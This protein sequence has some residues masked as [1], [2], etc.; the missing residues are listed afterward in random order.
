MKSYQ[1][2]TKTIMDTT[3]PN[4]VFNEYGESDYYTNFI[5]NILPEWNYGRDR[6]S[7]LM[8]FAD[9]V[10]KDGKNKKFDCIIGVSGGLDSSF[11]V[12]ITTE[13][14][15]LRPLIYHVDAGWN[16]EIA[17]SNIE[18]LINT[19]NLDLYTDVINWEEMKS[20]QRAFFHS[21]IP[22]QDC[23]QDIAF[24]SSLYEFARKNNIKYVFTGA[25]YS[26]EC[27]R[28]PNEWGAYPGID[29]TLINDIF[30][31]HG[32]GNLKTFPIIDIFKY[33]IFYQKIIGMKVFHPLNYVIY[34]K[35]DAE[36]LLN[37]KFG[38][39]SFQHKHH[40]S[41]FTRFIEDYWLPRKFGFDKR[42][43][44]LSSLILTGQLSRDEALERIKKPE[45]DEITLLNEKKYIADKLE[46]TLDEFENIFKGNN[47]TY[48]SYKSK[49]K[50]INLGIQFM[51]TFGL[52]KRLL[53]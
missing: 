6:M 29:K 46:F 52:E 53:R 25:N 1:I 40:E 19:L 47:K 48:N 3:D 51:R 28:E 7:D 22:E 10:R 14:M 50:L 8:N 33:K 2:C 17:V 16:S 37:E 34:T 44:H 32:N 18:K 38:W 11:C 23:P 12:Y 20:L 45:M 30:K 35:E 13:I 9:K 26:T 4:I 24:F 5:E 27:C 49:R 41:R 15:G 21:Q 36:K 43:A 39:E 31:K 42:K